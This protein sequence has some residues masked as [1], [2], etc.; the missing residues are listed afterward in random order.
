GAEFSRRARDW[1]RTAWQ[2]RSLMGIGMRDPVL[3]PPV[4]Q[5][6]RRDIA[7]CPAP[8]ELPDAGHFTQEQGAALARLS[9]ER[10][11]AG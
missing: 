9:V 7:G 10:F 2:G 6:L 5:A 4:M 8:I 11:S 3:G 1:W